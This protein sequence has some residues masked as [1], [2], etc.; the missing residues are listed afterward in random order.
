M[1][2]QRQFLESSG[3]NFASAASLI[4]QHIQ[5]P[6][7]VEEKLNELRQIAL[8]HAK[9]TLEF[10]NQCRAVNYVSQKLEVDKNVKIDKEYQIFLKSCE[11]DAK[12]DE[13]I[14]SNSQSCAAL[15][16]AISKKNN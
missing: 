13:Q 11:E 8:E 3:E 5:D 4:C 6:N 16:E 2:K 14:R 1:E 7:E 15:E 10:D 12:S 9:L